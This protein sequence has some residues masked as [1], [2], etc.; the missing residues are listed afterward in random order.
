MTMNVTSV[1]GTNPEIAQALLAEILGNTTGLSNI[2]ATIT[3]KPESFGKFSGDPFGLNGGIVLSTGY[4]A[5]VIGPNSYDDLTGVLNGDSEKNGGI[6]DEAVLTITFDAASATKAYFSYVFGSDE[7]IEFGG[8][9]FNDK[10]ELLINGVNAAKLSNGEEVSVNTLVPNQENSSTW[11][12]EF[13]DNTAGKASQDTELDGY[14]KFLNFEAN[15]APGANTITIRVKDVGDNEYD[16]AVFIKKGSLSTTKPVVPTPPPAPTNLDLLTD[17]ETTNVP[18]ITDDR[19]YEATPDFSGKGFKAGN[20]IKL[21]SKFEGL[22]G[23]TIVQADNTW[24]LTNANVGGSELLVGN[25]EIYAIEYDAESGLASPFS[26]PLDIFIDSTALDTDTIAPDA[27]ANLDLTTDDINSFGDKT[28][29][30]ND[31]NDR[32]PTISGTAEIDS[33]ITLYSNKDGIIGS[34]RVGRDGKWSTTLNLLQSGEHIITAE[35][36][37][38][39]E[40][41]SVRS[42][43]LDITVRNVPSAPDMSSASDTGISKTDN[44]TYN[45][46]P[47]FTGVAE[48]NSQVELFLNDVSVG[49]VSTDANGVWSFTPTALAEGTYQLKARAENKQYGTYDDFSN[50]LSFTIDT[51]KPGDLG[52]PSVPD[53]TDATDN[54]LSSIDNITSVK[55]PSFTGTAEPNSYV[56]ITSDLSGVLGTA[57]A[58]STGKWILNVSKRK[59]LVAGNH[60]ITAVAKD[61]AGNESVI[62]ASLSMTSLPDVSMPDLK[63]SSDSGISDTDNYTN[64]TTPTFTGTAELGST[65]TLFYINGETRVDIG[66][67]VA[68]T[69]D[70]E[71]GGLWEITA[72]DLPEGTYNIK[73]EAAKNGFQSLTSASLQ[74]TIDTDMALATPA[75]SIPDLSTVSD[76][77]TDTADNIT[78]NSQPTFTGTG[79][80][81]N[82]IELYDGATK[83]GSTTVAVN[84]T[85]SITPATLALGSHDISAKQIDKAGNVSA[86]SAILD[87]PNKVTIVEI[88]LANTLDLITIDDTG[89]SSTDNVTKTNTPTITGKASLGSTVEVYDGATK[90]GTATTDASGNWSYTAFALA[91]GSH[92]ITAKAIDIYGNEGPVSAALSLTI[93]TAAPGKPITPD[94]T[95][96]TDSGSSNVD[97]LTNNAKPIF[98]GTTEANSKVEVFIDG[99]SQGFATVS[100]G[101]WSYTPA[102]TL[103]EGDHKIK[104]QIT[105]LAGNVSLESDELS[106][107]VDLTPP[108]T[109]ATAPDMIDASDTGTSNIDNITKTNQPIFT[110]T[111]AGDAV[112][113]GIFIDGTSQGTVNVT[114][115][116]W[117][118]TPTT[119]ILDGKHYIEVKAIDNVDNRSTLSPRLDFTID[120]AIT[121]P[122]VS[123]I[124][125]DSGIPA[126]GIT[127]ATTLVFNGTAEA[128]SSVDVFLDE[129]KIGTT[130]ADDTGKW[131]LDHSGTTLPNKSYAVTAQATDKAGN[132]SLISNNYNLTV[133]T[134]NPN[135]PVVTGISTDTGASSTDGLTNDKNL[136]I[137]G[138]AE[139]NSTV[140][141]FKDGTKI[142][143]VT[144]N[145]TGNWLLD[146]Q[147]TTLS[148]GSYNFTAKATDKAANVSNESAPFTAKI[149][150]VAPTKPIVASITDDTGI[151]NSDGITNDNKLFING[152]AEANSTVE[153]YQGVTKIGTTTADASGNWTLNYQG[154]TLVDGS[155][156]LTAKSIDP[157]GNSASSDPFNLTIDTTNAAP[158]VTAIS[159]DSGLVGDHLTSA[160]TLIISGTAEANSS[161]DVFRN[162]MKIG[163]VLA[164][165]T[166]KWTIDDTATTLTDGNTYVFTAQSTDKA[167]NLSVLSPSYS[168]T[169][170][171][172]SP[173]IPVVSSITDDTGAFSNDGIT[174][175]NTLKINGTA[176]A[177]STVDVFQG[178]AKIGSTTADT[179]GNWTLDYT[180]TVLANGEYNFTAKAIDKAGNSSNESASFTV[181]IDTKNPNKP[182][183][184]GISDDTNIP[185]D[186]VTS[187]NTLKINGTAEA[188]S[189]VNIFQGTTQIGSTTTDVNGNWTLDYTGTVLANG[190][191][192]LTAKAIDKA[193]NVSVA[194]DPFNLIVDTEAPS[195]ATISGMVEADDTGISGDR[196]TSTLEPQFQGTAEVGST[197]QLID[198]DGAVIGTGVADTSG[199]WKIKTTP[200]KRQGT[201][202][203]K[204]VAIDKAGNVSAASLE[205]SFE[206]DDEAPRK[207]ATP[208]LTDATDTGASD[209]D[210]ITGN[211]KPEFAGTAES[212]SKVELFSDRDG[213]IGTAIADAAGQWTIK[214]IKKLQQGAHKIVSKATDIAGNTSAL[215]DALDLQILTVDLSVDQVSISENG[216]KAMVTVKLRD[217]V[218]TDKDVVVRLKAGGT[219][220]SSDYSLPETITIKAGENSG[221]VELIG[222]DDFFAEDPET[223][224]VEIDSVENAVGNGT[225]Q[226]TTAITSEDT[227]GVVISRT[228]LLTSE[229]GTSAN[230]T[231]KLASRPTDIVNI[232]LS[233]GDL[234]E[235]SI[236][237]PTLTFTPDDWDVVQTVTVTGLNDDLADGSIPYTIATD[238]TSNDATYNQISIPD[239]TVTNADNDTAGITVTPVS[240]QTSEAKGVA[241][242]DVVLNTQPTAD[243]TVKLVV[244]NAAEGELSTTTLTFNSTN[245]NLVQ[246][247]TVTGLNDDL[248]DG[249]ITYTIVTSATSSDTNYSDI[250]IDD[251]VVENVDDDTAGI[252]IAPLSTS[253][254]EGSATDSYSIVLN[255][256]PTSDVIV[257]ISTGSQ[258][259]TDLTTLIFTPTNWN[260]LQTVTVTAVN[261]DVA[262][263]A[264]T[265]T[266]THAIEST[267]A[268]Y[269]NLTD[270]TITANITDNDSA[271]VIITP[272]SGSTNLTEAGTTDSYTVVLSSRPTANVTVTIAGDAQSS[273]DHKILT[274]TPDTWDMAQTVTVTAVDDKIA[275]GLHTSIISHTATSSDKNYNGVVIASVNANVTD[276]DAAGIIFL[277]LSLSTTETGEQ[278]TLT[279]VL[280]SEPTAEV[281][282]TLTNGNA[283]EGGLSATTFTFDSGN[284][285]KP[286]TLIVTGKDDLVDDGDISYKIV[287]SVN[288]SD[289]IYGALKPVDV[290]VT[291]ADNDTAGVKI[292]S[293]GLF[294]TEAGGEASFMVVLTSKPTADVK[295]NLVSS[296]LGEGNVPASIVFT[297]ENW[298]IAQTVS[299]KGLEDAIADGNQSYKIQTSIS[300]DDTKYAAIDPADVDLINTDNDSPGVTI[301]QSDGNSQV[302]EGGETDTYTIVLN[303]QPT[304]NVT[305]TLT[306]GSQLIASSNT[307][308]F[309]PE[310]WNKAQTV[311][312]TAANDE[313]FEGNHS[314]TIAHT[315]SSNDSIYNGASVLPVVVNISDNDTAGIVLIPI[316]SETSEDGTTGSFEVALS[317]QPTA[318]VVLKFTSSHPTEGKLQ[319]DTLT[320]TAANWKTTQTITVKGSDDFEVDGNKPYTI[321]A[322]A[323]SSDTHYNVLSARAIQFINKDN[324]KAGV[325]LKPIEGLVTTE[326]GGTAN[327]TVVLTSKPS[328]NVI[329]NLASSNPAEGRVPQAVTFNANN[330]NQPQTV[331][332][333]GVDD[334][335]VDGDIKYTIATSITSADANYAAID[336]ADVILTNQDNEF[337]SAPIGVN[338][339][340]ELALNQTTN[341]TGVVATDAD[342]TVV[343][344]TIVTLPDEKQ[345]V[346]FLGDPNSGTQI[347]AGQVL[348]PDQIS[349]LFFRASGSFRGAQFAYTSTDNLGKRGNL[350]T[351]TLGATKTFDGDD[352]DANVGC[353]NGKGIIRKG[354]TRKDNWRGSQGRDRLMGGGGNDKIHG[355]ASA[356]VIRGG[357]GNDKLYGDDCSDSVNGDTGNDQMRGG[358]GFDRLFG[359]SGNDRLFGDQHSDQLSGG[360]G[361][362]RMKGGSGN[363]RMVGG[364]GNDRLFGGSG[365]DQMNGGL[366][367]DGLRG[368]SGNDRM[369]GSTGKDRLEG[370]SGNDRLEGGRGNDL[371]DGGNGNDWLKGGQ[372]QDILKGRQGNDRIDG[373]RGDDLL[374]GGNGRDVLKGGAGNDRLA[375]AGQSDRIS[376]GAGNDFIV[377]GASDDL[378]T[379]GTGRDRFVYTKF[380]ETLG[381]RITDFEVGRD[382]LDLRR[383]L[384]KLNINHRNFG[385]SVKLDQVGSSTQVKI[386]LNG[387][388]AGGFET[389]VTLDNVNAS[390]VRPNSFLL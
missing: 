259:G 166:N 2:Q 39:A 50:A 299:V 174:S 268:K 137:N 16:S 26:A 125:D 167:G 233:N 52:A 228:N 93:D 312:I 101:T 27:P 191:Y 295:V 37:D 336:P 390:S 146:Y 186:G 105:D 290:T 189:S 181:Q 370:G 332:V 264:H 148:D 289:A 74:V 223:I 350:A 373:G 4:A 33:I 251:V 38:W 97:N 22:I 208:D 314:S 86:N 182:V 196:L 308:T 377:G 126:D 13:I 162:G 334:K 123:A 163:T 32:T 315:V 339:T 156:V 361:K 287:T 272:L 111:V 333:S 83:I 327:F 14:T 378:L 330:W 286:Q 112:K 275:E 199:N 54:G 187:N 382:A 311:T 235:G 305:V 364:S 192:V 6:F 70:G 207:P 257:K 320:F 104:V 243:V 293:E 254:T 376:G 78:T 363:D 175:N 62:S 304:S 173:N 387:K 60:T 134:V 279:V 309:T 178:A 98:T 153:I 379:G 297:S 141:V 25:H 381:D 220:S 323:T 252:T 354:K 385:Q 277:S 232:A 119:A 258:I 298:N 269:N 374:K 15:I 45:T 42:T 53:L 201:Q 61:V 260:Q 388:A 270:A 84:G 139:A 161:V 338:V 321:T 216:G 193:G 66:S 319:Q 313:V 342:G 240:L 59:K 300:S 231:V 131:S 100:N 328:A 30:D 92:P 214:S 120:T 18:S 322:T 144:A 195:A 11:S 239:I 151:F 23:E 160:Q 28:N 190:N 82:T 41:V 176:E 155:Y 368:G 71:G 285:N 110:G 10:F 194:A 317:S 124:S 122:V 96:A 346:L 64:D 130:T 172:T 351:V 337:N 209:S 56:T 203:L 90:L 149:D 170:D 273:T 65:V 77:G 204:A 217:G 152:T 113:A 225:Q 236:D 348:R 68:N 371:L 335:R 202:K 44:I 357:K 147:S 345:G 5:Q 47:T 99:I 180:G 288:S 234:S 241:S 218:T 249:N 359:G 261:D 347:S 326:A 116:S 219:A 343:T 331:I 133:D 79:V 349:Q 341:L 154:T 127:N 210:N 135:A 344:Y 263:G 75:P 212:G 221:S 31:T 360:R 362:D 301:T 158:A 353:S 57:K 296:N 188:D 329:V 367:N 198:G 117:S 94:M 253:V 276:N 389:L 205:V 197:I 157:A 165:S 274:F 281:T 256:Q 80:A 19:T 291:N 179:N 183:I 242:F 35:A 306:T 200:K 121:Q 222:I 352:G 142:G 230:F 265:D 302:V 72:S 58:D 21:F 325:I 76:S 29:T 316:L 115:G 211:D 215:S 383:L 237:K 67:A 294:T 224:S 177:N 129:T 136:I 17:T 95:A 1:T 49:T 85:W 278:A 246:K 324:D 250:N 355:G 227:A 73:A 48:A 386:D 248:D 184:T 40:N 384:G 318:D 213:S 284:W 358:R 271:G 132:V 292:T 102:A 159:I 244:G 266:I 69:D 87:S 91:D 307:L 303:S 9:E 109:P 226:I 238:A 89:S 24:T 229:A 118:Y 282:L 168:V 20:K 114:G 283:S 356:D 8:T 140:D 206:I 7:F 262:E 375:G 88:P 3:G 255:S 366:D 340:S 81:G 51:T 171:A 310:D 12:P 143:T 103:T 34:A 107:T 145:A 164:D 185:T 128:N 247:V 150:T 280:D 55:S 36:K 138:T 369:Q 108:A 365:N 372:D 380:S 245:W 169:I 46:T 63:A 267:D 43:G 106:F